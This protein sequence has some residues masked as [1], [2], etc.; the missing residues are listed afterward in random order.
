[1]DHV[2]AQV[3]SPPRGAVI[4]YPY[5][6]DTGFL[7]Q[8]PYRGLLQQPVQGADCNTDWTDGLRWESVDALGISQK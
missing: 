5:S 1:M 4:G 3:D 7:E 8:P 6:F 2:A